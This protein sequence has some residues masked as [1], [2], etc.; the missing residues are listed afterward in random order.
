LPW[1]E[2]AR[3]SH[4]G[5]HAHVASWVSPSLAHLQCILPEVQ[6]DSLACQAE[7]TAKDLRLLPAVVD[8][9]GDVTLL[10][11]VEDAEVVLLAP[12]VH[13][14]IFGNTGLMVGVV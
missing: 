3:G 2:C 6:A 12:C 14:P 7:F 4:P 8:R 9:R 10:A 1:L 13:Q 5:P 11:M